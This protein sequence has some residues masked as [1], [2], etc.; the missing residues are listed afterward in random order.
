METFVVSDIHIGSPHCRHQA[1][2]NFLACLPAGATLVLNGDTLDRRGQPLGDE[3]RVTLEALRRRAADARVV[4][5]HGNHDRS[6]WV[7]PSTDFDGCEEYAVEDAGLLV[8]HGDDFHTARLHHR[9]FVRLFRRLHQWRILLGARPM[10]V[11]EYAK[12]FHFFY[13]ILC[14]TVAEN[15]VEYAREKGIAAIACGHVHFAEE[16]IIDGVRYFNT[17]SWTEAPSWYLHVTADTIRLVRWDD[18]PRP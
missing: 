14:D 1:I 17:G 3:D 16:R 12:R 7:T 11:A 13:R 6:E 10:H 18:T 8:A 4:W 9:W 15:A 5:V 2:R